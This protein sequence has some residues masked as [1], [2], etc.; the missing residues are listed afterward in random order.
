L[1]VSLALTKASNQFS[2]RFTMH[3]VVGADALAL[4]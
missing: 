1:R 4:Q 3:K 2:W